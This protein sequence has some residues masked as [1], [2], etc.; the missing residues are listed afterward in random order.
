MSYFL[1]NQASQFVT[2][3]FS[4][5]ILS[6]FYDVIRIFRNVIKHRRIWISIEDFI[7]WNFV[8]IFL[9]IMIFYSNNGILRWF[10]I[11]SAFLGAIIYHRGI[12][13]F[14]VKYISIIINTVINILLKK[15]IK[16]AKILIVKAVKYPIKLVKGKLYVKKNKNTKKIQ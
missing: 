4:G 12:G 1:W 15:P 11:G 2:A 10:I 6:A 9:Y 13:R 3:M 8:G 5:M 7:F 14:V 16:K